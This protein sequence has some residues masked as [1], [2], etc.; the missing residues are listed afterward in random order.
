LGEELNGHEKKGGGRKTFI[1]PPERRI[2][3]KRKGKR[4]RL[5][6]GKTEAVVG[7]RVSHEVFRGKVVPKGA[8]SRRSGR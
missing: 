2:N 3:L 7:G 5:I 4:E 6:E 8:D 1:F